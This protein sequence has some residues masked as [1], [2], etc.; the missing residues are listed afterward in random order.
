[1]QGPRIY[2]PGGRPKHI[3]Q[4][5]TGSPTA[6]YDCGPCSI[7]V[8]L[9]SKSRNKI[10]PN[11]YYTRR[12]LQ[13]IRR[14]MVHYPSWP[15]INMLNVEESIDSA[16]M[17]NIFRSRHLDPPDVTWRTYSFRE[18]GHALRKGKAVLVG[19]DYGRLN[20]RQ[21]WLSGSKDFRKG[22]AILLR[23]W[24]WHKNRA[25]TL[26][27]DPLHDGRR[28]GIPRGIQTVMLRRY[29]KNGE[30]WGI[31]NPGRGRVRAAIIS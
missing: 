28:A 4:L 26:L 15:A 14:P 2:I 9:E 13:T 12:W 27:Y 5:Q 11:A 22:H 31:P 30:T 29:L 10:R 1:M 3:K 6:G 8:G 7:L 23:G 21:P 24:K 25:W 18:I 16:L 17:T 20:D 19:I